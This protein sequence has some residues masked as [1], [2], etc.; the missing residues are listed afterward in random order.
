M[1]AWLRGHRGG[2]WG[3][4][5]L[6]LFTGAIFVFL[7]A[8]IV[9]AV[10]YSFN[11]GFLGKQTSSFT[12]F[13]LDAYKS[14]WEKDE[15]RSSFTTSLKVA[16]FASLIAVVLGTTAGLTLART[17]SR[18]IRGSLGSLVALLLVVPEIVLGVALLL[19][20]TQ[21]QFTLGMVTM[22]AGLSPFPTAVVAMIV[23]SRALALDAK[24]DEAASDLGAR[25][26]HVFRDV[27]LPALR[28]AI[29]SGFMLAFAFS[30]D[31]LV[32]AQMLSTPAVDPLT[33]YL[34]GTVKHGGV[35]PDGYAIAA[36]MLGVTLLI[37]AA[38]GLI[39]RFDSRRGRASSL[40]ASVGGAEVAATA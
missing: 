17:R 29:V 26:I 21:A 11:K 24:L 25:G 6:A 3:E 10:L 32:V 20:F 36:M 1:S 34:F 33:V 37:L 31:D 2:S 7:F 4:R 15:I 8:P 13:S 28:P 5:G 23:R 14:V 12:G 22:V 35:T 39:Y 18:L 40:A 27:T 19:F 30:F 9:V 16:I 38:A